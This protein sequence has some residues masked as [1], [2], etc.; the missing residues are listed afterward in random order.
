MKSFLKDVVAQ[1][2]QNHDKIDDIKFILPSKRAG[3]FLKDEFIKQYQKTGFAPQFTSIE[4]FI[5]S[6]SGLQYANNIQ[7]LFELYTVYLSIQKEKPE[8]FYSF[9]KW[10]QI[11][12]QDFNEIDRYLVEPKTIF[13]YLASIQEIHHW[14][15]SEEKTELQKKYIEFWNGLG[16]YYFAYNE[17][18]Q[19]K[20]IGYQGMV[21]KEAI[22]NLE[23]YLHQN[24]NTIHIFVGF[25]ALNKAE[26]KIIQELLATDK[27]E[28]YWDIDKHFLED[29]EHDAGLFIRKHLN[30][31]KHFETNAPN[32][33]FDEF[34]TEKNIQ[35][36]GIPKNVGQAK[37]V[38]KLLNDIQQANGLQHTAVVL[39]NEALLP[40]VLNE[41]PD[42]IPEVN[43]TMGL[44]L[45]ETPIASLFSLY[46]H[47]YIHEKEQW[48]YRDVLN[49]LTHSV[50]QQLLGSTANAI[51]TDIQTTNKIQISFGQLIKNNENQP[52]ALSHFFLDP[53]TVSPK[54]LLQHCF[55]L[56]YDLK[57]KLETDKDANRLSLEYLYRFYE[58][59]N[60]LQQYV[61]N[62]TY[63]A[64][65]KTLFSIYKELISSE[66]LDFQGEPLDGLQIMGMLESR[67]LD[68]E[69]VILTSVNEGILPSGKS[70]NS[71]IPFD[72][73]N[74]LEMPTY[75]E[76]DAVYT[77]HFYR[78]LQRAKN[79][80][81][82]YNTEMSDALK[83]GEKS[84]FIMQ[85]EAERL[86]NH[87]L[88]EI[89]AS[90]KID[91]K[92]EEIEIQKDAALLERLYQVAERGFSPSSLTN[93]VRNP[94]DF[95][96][97]SVLG[98]RQ[99]DEVEETIA[100]NTLGTIVHNTLENLYKPFENELLSEAIIETFQKTF[101][102]EL[103]KQFAEVYK[104][105]D[106]SKGKNL[107]IYHVAQAYVKR[108]LETEK[109]LVQQHE[110]KIV[111]I[112]GD[113]KTEINIPGIDKK[114][115]LKGKVDR[116][117]EID[118]Q[119]RIVDY[120]S[121]KVENKHVEIVEWNEIIDS[122][123]FSKAFQVLA[124]AYMYYNQV[125]K[126]E[127]A[128]AGI[129]SF[130]NLQAG[131]LQFCTK[132]KRAAYAKKDFAITPETLQE[133][134]QQ[135]HQLILEILNPEIP[136]TEKEV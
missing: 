79:V 27:A 66:T 123:D 126:F 99:Q 136:F 29:K 101:E 115:I 65:V 119:L 31:W 103:K 71:F 49:L 17:A 116:V 76:K 34:T 40:P 61:D 24:E 4:T 5:E 92:T 72:I 23:H 132:D 130:K 121:G 63:I 118:G 30:S 87:K 110:V 42:S 20:G 80:Y 47:L 93:Y 67:N 73:K 109:E 58:L 135:L 96:Q 100:A 131:F 59:F 9:S 46:F 64:D 105:A 41:I 26:E 114:I 102:T 74:M 6:I 85:L 35:L 50:A 13:P 112:E 78:L 111:T 60:Q 104:G 1:V 22:E 33:I 122:Y 124:Y 19:Q 69:T 127:T 25:N 129:I 106:Y 77:Y 45:S 86:P 62:Y 32:W 90:P 89:I 56:I 3:V 37:Y 57:Q 95:Y 28:I 75:K 51:I 39:G 44:P 82:L 18:L 12:L 84:R 54:V 10:G 97:Q 36:I 94:L 133:F 11:L 53:K 83:G 2:L 98:I 117:D 14:S 107:L 91:P 81:L 8:D 70:N 7:L 113:Y 21:Y 38:S 55:D 120:K 43:I 16:D 88:T 15:L 108:F 48:Y 125:S 52:K 68:F 128:E 134:E